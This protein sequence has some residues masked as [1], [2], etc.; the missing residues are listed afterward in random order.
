MRKTI[1]AESGGGAGIAD[2]SSIS[3]FFENPYLYEKNS[4]FEDQFQ[5]LLSKNAYNRTSKYVLY[6]SKVV[7][8][9]VG[10]TI[11]DQL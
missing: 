9:Q 4:N 3:A 7:L 5:V 2:W 1:T 8:L 10:I 11:L 6:P